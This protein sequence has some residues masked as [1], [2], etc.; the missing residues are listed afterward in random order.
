MRVQIVHD[1]F[2]LT[3]RSRKIVVLD[4]EVGD[5]VGRFDYLSQA[6]HFARARR[7]LMHPVTEN[8]SSDE[9][10]EEE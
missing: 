9:T 2:V 10:T 7:Q 5:P 1:H 4:A 3:T 8:D 6:L